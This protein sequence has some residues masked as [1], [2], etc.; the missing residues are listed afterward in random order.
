M[1]SSR[2]NYARV[3]T[4]IPN[5]FF[6]LW[7]FVIVFFNSVKTS[8]AKNQVGFSETIDAITYNIGGDHV[9]IKPS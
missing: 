8:K 5:S 4:Q 7:F 9:T 3:G 1:G 2:N 6:N